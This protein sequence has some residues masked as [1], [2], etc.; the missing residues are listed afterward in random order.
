MTVIRALS[1]CPLEFYKSVACMLRHSKAV[2][3]L[4][5]VKLKMCGRTS[6]FTKYG[7]GRWHAVY[8]QCI[9]H[10]H[11]GIFVPRIWL[12]LDFNDYTI[13]VE[14]I[15]LVWVFVAGVLG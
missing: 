6:V 11:C 14:L 8:L 10:F 1:I 4:R 5:L 15:C 9:L 12:Y 7:G 2:F 3:A 13:K